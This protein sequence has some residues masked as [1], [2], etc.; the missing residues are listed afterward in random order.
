MR[1]KN[2]KKNNIQID[3]HRASHGG[4]GYTGWTTHKKNKYEYL[5]VKKKD[6]DKEEGTWYY[7]LK[8]RIS[9]AKADGWYPYDDDNSTEEVEEIVRYVRRLEATAAR[10]AKPCNNE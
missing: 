1:G 9:S 4:T 2:L 7:Y 3:K 5:A 8:K 10:F 6:D